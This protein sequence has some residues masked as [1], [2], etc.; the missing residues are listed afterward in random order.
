MYPEDSPH[1]SR[2]TEYDNTQ[3]WVG[4]LVA[5]GP[6][7]DVRSKGAR[8]D[9]VTDDTAGIQAAFN[10]ATSGQTVRFPT[11]TYNHTGL[12]VSNS[13]RIIFDQGAKLYLI[14]NS[15]TISLNITADDDV[16]VEGGEI[17][18]NRANQNHA[19]ESDLIRIA[20]NGVTIKDT[21]LHD[22]DYCGIYAKNKNRI[23]IIRVRVE[24][25]R[26]WGILAQGV[27]NDIYDILVDGCTVDRSAEGAAI[28]GGG[29]NVAGYSDPAYEVRGTR[30]VNNNVLLPTNPTNN[31]IPIQLQYAEKENVVSNN[32]VSGGGIGI[33]IGNAPNTC[34]VGNTI[35][36]AK[37]YGIELVATESLSAYANIVDGNALTPEGI[38]VD[39]D[40]CVVSGNII[41]NLV[42]SSSAK[43]IVVAS[44]S[45]GAAISGNTVN[46]NASGTAIQ[47]GSAD[48][49]TISGNT[50]S[51]RISLGTGAQYITITGNTFYDGIM[52]VYVGATDHVL[53]TGNTFYNHSS[54]GIRFERAAGTTDYIT[55]VGN[56]FESSTIPVQNY[57]TGTG[58]FGTHISIE[59]N[60]GDE[61]QFTYTAAAPALTV[62]VPAKID[63]TD[64]AVDATLADG[65]R[66]GQIQTIVMIEDSNPST[67]TIA[68]HETEDTEVATFDAV[69]E[70][71]HLIWTGTQW[72]TVSNSCTFL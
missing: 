32:I 58:A 31:R 46:I 49:C 40:D 13:I 44:G 11:G 67:V 57:M 38:S 41:K 5:K 43:A 9:G 70:Y 65:T 29:I 12:T 6:W 7:V 66:I 51:A 55:I 18:G 1:R 37:S 34:L 62:G 10:A 68:H 16:I 28:Y 24:D 47:V 2:H 25:V 45:D 23:K 36:N 8:G 54:A 50:L 22:G 61:I 53:I 26:Y 60:S 15:N 63:S 27:G 64:R 30:I 21:Y 69:D 72:A 33:S 14:D 71:L 56:L 4:D 35:Y 59:G 42:D 3:F 20:G 39:G 52:G 48:K 17:Q 19:G